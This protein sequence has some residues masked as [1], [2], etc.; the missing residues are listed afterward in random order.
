MIWLYFLPAIVF[1]AF[2][3]LET[4]RPARA[5]AL[6]QP[7]SATWRIRGLISLCVYMGLGWQLPLFWD[8]TLAQ[9]QLFDGTEL[10]TIGGAI[11]A[12]LVL[13]LG[14]FLWHRTLHAVPFL[15]HHLHQMHHSAE[16]LDTYGAFYFNP[17][18]MAGFIAVSSVTFALVIG[19]TTEAAV[20]AG[21]A[22]TV[23]SVFQHANIRT[24]AWLGYFVQR[25][26]SHFLHHERGVHARNYGDLP[27]F[28]LLFGSFANGRSF[29][30]EVGFYDGAS[31]RIGEVLLGKDITQPR[32]ASAPDAHS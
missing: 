26:E 31:S 8:A 12:F 23:L 30:G 14:I 9:Y 19:V 18:D 32:P 6:T 3:I 10:G 17:L 27:V 22:A 21:I 11:A 16:R 4:I 2:A 5:Y 25:P 24:P 20:I 1:A 13:E 29:D 15:W 7:S 28:D